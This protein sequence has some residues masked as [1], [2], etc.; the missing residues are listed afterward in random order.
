M[1]FFRKD[2]RNRDNQDKRTKPELLIHALWVLRVIPLR[3][4]MV[5][6]TRKGCGQAESHLS[7]RA[8]ADA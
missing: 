2:T 7:R 3:T 8:D 5:C 4:A 1:M 6:W